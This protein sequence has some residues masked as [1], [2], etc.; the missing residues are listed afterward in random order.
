MNVVK[1]QLLNPDVPARTQAR[2]IIVSRL[3][4]AVLVMVIAVLLTGVVINLTG[5][6]PS[7][8]VT[9]TTGVTVYGCQT[10]DSCKIMYNGEGSWTI[11]RD[12]P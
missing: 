1:G 4:T 8:T 5:H 9:D 12:H 10:E 11:E 7:P 2:V 6:G 3:I